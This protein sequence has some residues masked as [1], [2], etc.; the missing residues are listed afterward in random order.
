MFLTQSIS[1][2]HWYL[3]SLSYSLTDSV[4]KLSDFNIIEATFG[5]SN[6]AVGRVATNSFVEVLY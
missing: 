2:K 6:L 1:N 5:K 3:L 4:I